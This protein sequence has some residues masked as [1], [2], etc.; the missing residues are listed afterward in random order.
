MALY[1]ISPIATVYRIL[2]FPFIVH[3]VVKPP[4]ATAKHKPPPSDTLPPK[5]TPTENPPPRPKCTQASR[6][7]HPALRM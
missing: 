2:L 6:T 5:A 1:S 7:D 3:T 4:E